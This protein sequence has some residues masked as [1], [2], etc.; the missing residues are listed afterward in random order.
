MSGLTVRPEPFGFAQEN[1]VEEDGQAVH[2]SAGH[3]ERLNLRL[4][5]LKL[6]AISF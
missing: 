3:H 2:G 6:V 5:R 1:L 4:S